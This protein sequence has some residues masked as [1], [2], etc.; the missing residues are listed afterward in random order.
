M[1]RDTKC[2]NCIQKEEK[3]LLSSSFAQPPPRLLPP[4]MTPLLP[5][6]PSPL[7]ANHVT[8]QCCR[9]HHCRSSPPQPCLTVVVGSTHL[10]LTRR[11]ARHRHSPHTVTPFYK[12]IFA[13]KIFSSQLTYHSNSS[14]F[15]LKVPRAM[16]RS[17]FQNRRT[18]TSNLKYS[19][20]FIAIR[21][22]DSL[23]FQVQGRKRGRK[24]KGKKGMK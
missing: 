11:R 18:I 12:S 13:H 7:S 17:P 21:P 16:S 19:L 15:F 14:S 5:P 4:P 1:Q 22:A 2:Y 9:L 10:H 23:W 6:S 24:R 3:N 20:C 8:K